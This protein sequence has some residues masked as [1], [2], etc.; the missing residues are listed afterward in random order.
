LIR[1]FFI[2]ICRKN[3]LLSFFVLIL[4][5]FNANVNAAVNDAAIQSNQLPKKLSEF[6]F[7]ED[8]IKQIPVKNVIPYELISPLFS[9]YARKQRFV[10]VPIGKKATHR[11][12]FVYQFPIGTALIKTF[13]YLDDERNEESGR[14]LLETRV[15]LRKRN[16]WDAASYVWNKETNDAD[17]KI[18]GQSINSSWLSKEGELMSVRYRVPNKNQCQEC[19]ESNTKIIPI[20]PK[21][22]NLNKEI[23]YSDLNGE[24]NQLR[25]WLSRGIIDSYPE[26]IEKV[27]GWNDKNKDIEKRARSY[28]AINCGHCHSPTGNAASSGLYLNFTEDRPKQLGV[29]K[30]P[31]AAGRGSGD[32]LYSIVPGKPE[33]SILLYRMQST[34]PGIMMPE[35]GRAL[36][37]KEGID[38]IANWITSLN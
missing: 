5:L 24:L 2:G 16:G 34:D 26:S 1:S 11:T 12:D 38:L 30:K 23:F 20:G 18:A 32:K 29:L 15:L 27:V 28:L 31:V 21:A 7:F 36:N 8:P 13:Y 10:Y 14:Q 6:G 17:L 25:Y 33:E 22:R 19:H 4:L 3:I 35:S 37:H 9:D